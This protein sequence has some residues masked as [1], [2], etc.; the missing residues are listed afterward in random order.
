M[1]YIGDAGKVN[2]AIRVETNSHQNFYVTVQDINK[3]IG[4]HVGR[5]EFPLSDDNRLPERLKQLTII[6]GVRAQLCTRSYESTNY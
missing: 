6:K 4:E 1:I 2:V 3:Y 5:A